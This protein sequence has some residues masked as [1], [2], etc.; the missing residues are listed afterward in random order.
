MIND[1]LLPPAPQTVA[2]MI[3][4]NRSATISR[5]RLA[6]AN[7]KS[8]PLKL[9]LKVPHAAADRLGPLKAAVEEVLYAADT[10]AVLTASTA[11]AAAA[12]SKGAAASGSESDAEGW[13][14]LARKNSSNG[15]SSSSGGSSMLLSG[16]EYTGPL[17]KRGS[18]EVQLNKFTD[19]GLELLVKVRCCNRI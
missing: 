5:G 10:S 2:D 18:V 7:R 13:V 4:F 6:S 8:E 11:A 16:G 3:V 9:R 14:P 15:S 17:V 19:A 12:G 1:L